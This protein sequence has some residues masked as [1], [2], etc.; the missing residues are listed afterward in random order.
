MLFSN[1]QKQKRAIA[2][3]VAGGFLT[4]PSM[5]LG[6]EIRRDDLTGSDLSRV[7]EIVKPTASFDKAERFERMSAGAA[8]TTIN[9]SKD[10]FSQHLKNLDFSGQERFKLGNGLFRKL[11]VSSPSSTQASDG[12]GPL[13]NA[14][15]CQRCHLKD[16]RGHPP[17]HSA[18][19]ATS[20]FLRLSIP[21]RNTAERQAILKGELD[22]ITEP[23][24]GKQLQDF[25]IPELAAE[26]RMVISYEEIEAFLNGGER[27]SLRKPSYD[28][29]DL[30]YG[31]L[32]D[33]VM[34]S[35]RVAPQM[36]GL[37]LIEAIHP[38]DII[39]NAKT[40]QR[41][42]DAVKGKVSWVG[43]KSEGKR[44]IGRFGW[45]AS[46]PTVLQ[47]SAG[48]FEG[49][50]G[51]SN[52]IAPRHSGDCTE[53]QQ[54]CLTQATGVQKRLGETEAPSPVLELVTF[55]SR[56]LAVPARRNINNP[57]VLK[58]KEIFYNI[59]CVTCHRP[60]YVTS[61]EGDQEEL[62]FQLIWPYTDLLLH[63]MGA[64]L[65]DN[66]PVG[67]ATGTQWRTPPL[68]GIGLTKE[69]SGHTYFLHDGRARNLTEAILWHGGEAEAAQQAFVNLPK[70][71]RQNLIKFL[72]SL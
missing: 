26:G 40:Q 8:T 45:K 43:P 32:A 57:E 70:N 7:R 18:D 42:D 54:A 30:S 50:I 48:A 62:K 24:Y 3:L 44:A 12:L 72:E 67:T 21:P 71:E 31:P 56:N 19:T 49:D 38:A 41:S 22:V 68:W 9:P 55:Y 27:V 2:L 5:V 65:A 10:A 34:L 36:I 4:L 20:M 47:Q 16:G 51:I 58:G 59:G 25:S 35:P 23:T 60:K 63:D 52:D 13:F 46:T 37:G 53:N 15:S 28:I 64:G 17:Q 1:N 14:R 69:V 61:R 39:E 33:D 66:R 29:A 6:E 11:W